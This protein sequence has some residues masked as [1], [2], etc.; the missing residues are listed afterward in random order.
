M[1]HKEKRITN[2]A[3]C[4]VYR[5]EYGSPGSSEILLIK[6][7]VGR[8]VWGL[9]KGHQDEGETLEAT[10]IRETLEEAGVAVELTGLIGTAFTVNGDEHKTVH[11]YWATVVGDDVP[12]AH[13]DPDGETAE[14]KWF[15]VD[16]LPNLHQYQ[17]E[18]IVKGIGAIKSLFNNDSGRYDL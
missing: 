7:F 3:G 15:N 17:R 14:A 8:D 6:P 16:E 13:L 5:G 18:L 9:P 11:I 10:A 4:L 2:S 1:K 12:K